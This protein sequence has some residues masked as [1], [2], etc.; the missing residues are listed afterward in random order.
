MKRVIVMI[1]ICLFLIGC[2]NNVKNKQNISIDNDSNNKVSQVTIYLFHWNQCIHCQ[3]E[4]EWLEQ[5]DNK[6]DYLNVNY[7]EVTEFEDFVSQIR[8]K[9]G[10]EDDYVPLT[11]IGDQYF[12]GF[13]GSTKTKINKL[14]DSYKGKEYCDIINYIENNKDVD[15]CHKINEQFN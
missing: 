15:E 13:S 14:I 4:K 8:S 3:E 7:Y 11:V 1:I 2:D 6:Y 5:M 9:L 12:V 10:I